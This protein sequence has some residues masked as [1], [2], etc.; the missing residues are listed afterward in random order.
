MDSPGNRNGTERWSNARNILIGC[1]VVLLVGALLLT[2][3]CYVLFGRGDTTIYAKGYTEVKFN[4]IKIGMTD[5][6][7]KRILGEPLGMSQDI[8]FTK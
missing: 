8:V 5:K 7:V 3:A 1:A 4:S 6:Q 2:A